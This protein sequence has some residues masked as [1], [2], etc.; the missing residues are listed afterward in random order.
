MRLVLLAA[1]APAPTPEAVGVV[2]YDEATVD[3]DE[4][5][6]VLERIRLRA[7]AA[8]VIEDAVSAARVRVASELPRAAIERQIARA[9]EIDAAEGAY[10]E[11]RIADAVARAATVI[12]ELRADP[13]APG[14]R[15]LLV[16]A[17]L[18]S[19]QIRWT[20]GDNDGSDAELRA[21]IALDPEGMLASRR[22]PPD[23]AQRHARLREEI[24]QARAQWTSLAIEGGAGAE[25]E[26]DDEVG[27]RPVPPGEHVI[28]VRR[29]G[30][31]PVAAVTSSGF[32]V[33]P[34]KVE[35]GAGLPRQREAAE[36][37]CTSLEL[38]RIVVLRRR[39]DLIGVQGYRCG[40]GFAGPW[41][42]T[43]DELDDGIAVGLGLTGRSGGWAE[44]AAIAD[45][46]PWP[47]VRRLPDRDGPPP[48]VKK[49]WY[50]RAWVWT[51]VG[52]VVV[53]G[54][55]T[56]TVLA[57]RRAR[58]DLAVDADSFLRP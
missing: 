13:L 12:A 31:A 41:Y 7:G 26:I 15:H 1:L 30:A 58:G 28:V 54:V 36:R 38:S 27:V 19:A 21:A 9:A 24:L 8:P 52:A 2:W 14:S 10:R 56:G 35:L 4:K 53:G 39:G 32:T 45:S 55:V 25:I 33:P 3:A 6:R 57:V 29:I 51:V 47:V 34:P 46:A 43:F 48:P 16:R 22:V 18:L 23:L 20:E 44:H 5:Q 37:V 50:R 11:G 42:G 17:H 40:R 49:P